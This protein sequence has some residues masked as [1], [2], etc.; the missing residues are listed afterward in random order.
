MVIL[1]GAESCTGKTV[2]AQKL[3][4]IYKI[5]YLSV[6]HL[7]MGLFKADISCGFTPEDSNEIIE[8]RLWPILRGIITT[9]IENG[10]NIIIEGCYLFPKRLKEFDD[11]YLKHI[12]AV[13]MGFSMD[14]IANKMPDIIRYMSVI[15][16]R[17]YREGDSVD[18]ITSGVG[19]FRKMCDECSAN[20]FEIH[21]NYEEDTAKIY[22][23]IDKE[24]LRLNK[25]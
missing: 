8:A 23:W 6:D 16:D 7:K 22:R 5:P 12:I 21:E 18:H 3:L 20:Y 1:I 9:N 10:Q 17:E 24:I 19:I 15:E 13:Y 25:D 11:Y 4:E 2:M 14:Y